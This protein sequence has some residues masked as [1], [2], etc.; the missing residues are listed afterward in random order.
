M[1]TSKKNL[2]AFF[3]IIIL[4]LIFE[5]LIKIYFYFS[6]NDI[7]AFKN[8]PGRY[9]SSYFTGFELTKNWEI[10]HKSL[11]E[12]INSHGFKSPNLAIKKPENTYRIFCVGGSTVYGKGNL[13]NWPSKLNEIIKKNSKSALNYEVINAGVPAYTSFHTLS[14]LTSKLVQFDPDLIN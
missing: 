12:T 6:G 7:K 8:F 5:F 4:L 14:Q 11:K 2:F 13:N 3:S 1:I 10:N 9:S